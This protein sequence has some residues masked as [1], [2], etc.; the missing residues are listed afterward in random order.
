MSF[1]P[2]T[3]YTQV[4]YYTPTGSPSSPNHKAA[5]NFFLSFLHATACYSAYMISP[6]RLSVRPSATRVDH[7]K[8]VEVRIMKISPYGSHTFGASSLCSL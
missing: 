2:W 5:G 3:Q 6:V 1:C 7:T 4:Q 8:K